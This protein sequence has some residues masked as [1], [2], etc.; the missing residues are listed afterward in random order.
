MTS[1]FD[2]D[3]KEM[4]AA[5]RAQRAETL[6]ILEDLTETQWSTEI[7]PRWRTREVAGHLVSTDKASVTGEYPTWGLRPRKMSSIEEWNDKAV[8]KW[9]DRPVPELLRAL[10]KYGRRFA[11]LLS[12][13][14]Q[15]LSN[16]AFP[17]PFGKVS[18]AW[19]GMLRV[20]DEWIHVED[21]RR[22]LQLPADDSFERL[23]PAATFLLA[24]IPIQTLPEI[25]AGAGGT[26]EIGFSDVQTQ[27]L[28][29]DLGTRTFGV[30][31]NADAQISGPAASL[32]MVAAGR[33]KWRETEAAGRLD[34]K[35]DRK[36]AE[37][38]LDVLR[39]V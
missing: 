12:L 1:V 36:A 19:L 37:T 39:V 33:D 8:A 18:T 35:G 22:A 4:V 15:R 34:I 26:V 11:R 2:F 5:L 6:A 10:E 30:D 38:L 16:A 13:P 21:I 24:G 31:L 32:I 3:K 28:G 9:A 23:R 27:K 25:P 17:T 7:V 29:V 20:Y 14:P